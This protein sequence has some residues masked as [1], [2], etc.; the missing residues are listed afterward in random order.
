[1]LEISAAIL[2]ATGFL[3][4]IGLLLASALAALNR[5]CA[6]RPK[7]MLDTELVFSLWFLGITIAA[8]TIA[9]SWR[10]IFR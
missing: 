5:A 10:I 9:S 2:I 3:F 7:R 1:M 4:A 6:P 8:A